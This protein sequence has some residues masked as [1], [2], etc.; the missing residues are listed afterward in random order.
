MLPGHEAMPKGS[1]TAGAVGP[2]DG[3]PT[4]GAT[5][6][7]FGARARRRAGRAA[8]LGAFVVMA[9]GCQY[10]PAYV[11]HTNASPTTV[12]WWCTSERAADL[13]PADCKALS[14]QIDVALEVA[15]SHPH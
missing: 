10:F 11:R 15:Q 8:L 2:D 4:G 9:T 1:W 7:I 13:S 14:L 12:P 6:V 5:M 3:G